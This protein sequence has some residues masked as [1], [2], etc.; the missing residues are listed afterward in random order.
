MPRRS[1]KKAEYQ[2]RADEA[3]RA[4]LANRKA[5]V[6]AIGTAEEK[7]DQQQE[8]VTEAQRVLDERAAEVAEAYNK[9]LDGG[10]T[11]AELKDLGI[12]R[13]E[14]KPSKSPKTSASKTG[15]TGDASGHPSTDNHNGT[16]NHST[17][18]ES[19]AAPAHQ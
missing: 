8:A 9:A 6:G 4:Q 19:T 3:I 18:S 14:A 13:P 16:D 5:L 7:Y 17:S 12:T 11:A 15:S 1:S 10:W 2:A